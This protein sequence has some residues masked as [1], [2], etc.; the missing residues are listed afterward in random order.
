MKIKLNAQSSVRIESDSVIYFDP[1]MI[2]HGTNDADII[3]ITHPHHDHFSPDDIAK[4]SNENTIIVAPV[5][6]EDKIKE[7]DVPFASFFPIKP[8]DT[9]T[10]LGIRVSAVPAYNTDKP[11]HKKEYGWVGYVIYVEDT[12]IYAAG[13]IDA[14]EEGEALDVDIAF[15]PIGGTFTMNYE[16]AAEFINTMRPAKVI[17]YH[18]GTLVGD[19]KD[20][21][22]FRKL[23]E[24]GIDVELML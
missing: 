24:R 20:G 4:L 21:K 9:V 1:Y 13:D 2:K 16:E 19:E 7:L 15:V 5:S 8:G 17:P 11:M 23:I 14:I 6:M 3:F 10:V 22:R 18:Y 12:K